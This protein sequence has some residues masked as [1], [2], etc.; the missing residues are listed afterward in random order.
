MFELV[1][2]K[3]TIFCQLLISL[4][5]VKIFEPKPVRYNGLLRIQFVPF[6]SILLHPVNV[7]TYII[8]PTGLTQVEYIKFP[9]EGVRIGGYIYKLLAEF[10]VYILTKLFVLP[11]NN[12]A[13]LFHKK[14]A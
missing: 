6:Q 1:A 8:S 11:I 4:I 3:Q 14:S 5:N 7:L 12:L 2:S 9:K 13:P 10:K